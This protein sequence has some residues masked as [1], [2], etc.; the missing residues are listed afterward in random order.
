MEL[1][2]TS[3]DAPAEG[4]LR[5]IYGLSFELSRTYDNPCDPAEIAAEAEFELPS[6][7]RLVVPAFWFQDYAVV[8]GTESYEQYLP[9]GTAH[10]RARFLASEPGA[11]QVRLRARDRG[12]PAAEAG[13]F[14]CAIGTESRARGPVGRHP[15][16]P[17]ALAFADGFPYHPRGHNVAFED[18]N[19]ELDGSSYYRA[20]LSSLAAA[21]ENWTRFW[22]TDFARTALEWGRSHFSGFYS[23]AGVYSQRAAWRVDR[24]MD[25]ALAGDIQV[26]LVLND[27]GQFSSYVN[28]RW[29]EGNPYGS[30][31]GGPVPQ[32][33]PELFFTNPSAREL[34]RRRLRYIVARWGA[35]P[36]LLCWELWNEVQFAGSQARNFRSDA[37]TRSAVVEWHRE[38]ASRLK[39]LDP[40]GHMVT[41]SS[42]DPGYPGW[43]PIWNL[44][45][46]DMVQ[47]HHYAQPAAAR[48]A[49][50]V[51]YVDAA[52]QAYGKPV[53]VAEM[54]VKASAEPESNYNP[55]TFR[56]NT[57][58]PARERTGANRGHLSAGTTLRNG[59]WAAAMRR[60]G[61]MNWWWGCY[62]HPD[63]RQGRGSPDFPLNERLFP[64]LAE[65][66]GGEHLAPPPQ[67]AALAL[68]GELVGYGL[69]GADRAYVW[70][71][72]A[73]E[74]YDSGFGPA[75]AED[76]RVEGASLTLTGLNSGSYVVSPFA[77]EAGALAAPEFL[78]VAANGRLQVP[79]PPVTG[80]IALK[81]T[82]GTER[83]WGVVPRSARVWVTAETAGT[84]VTGHARLHPAHGSPAPAA[85]AILTL[86]Q[87][88][89]PVS[90]LMVPAVPAARSCWSAAEIGAPAEVGWAAANP[91]D[92]GAVARL[93]LFDASGQLLRTR[94]LEL[95]PGGHTARFLFE[96]FPGVSGPFRGTLHV[97]SDRPLAALTL[98]GTQNERGEFVLTTLPA[99]RGSE[100]EA[101]GAVVL[102]QAT[103]GGGYQTEWLMVNPYDVGLEGTL[104]FHRPDGSPWA[105]AVNG[106][107]TPERDY[108][109]APHGIVREI[110]SGAGATVEPGYCTLDAGDG[111]LPVAAAVI[112]FSRPGLQSET[113]VPFVRPAFSAATFWEGGSE[114]DTGVAL[115]NSSSEA[116]RVRLELFAR[117]GIEKKLQTEIDLPPGHHT[118]RLL[119]ELFPELPP[120]HGL[121]RCA[122]DGPVG[123]MALRMRT[124]PRGDLLTSSLRMGDAGGTAELVFPRLAFGGAY[125]ERFVLLNPGDTTAEGRL[126]FFDSS[127][128]PVQ[129]LFK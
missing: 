39:E 57:A 71:R 64:P 113:G 16:D 51:E 2:F 111:R 1:A 9:V 14:A 67:N 93:E 102:P 109:I 120:G 26:Q 45:A 13:P 43:S 11:H 35:Y 59:I 125:E 110:S 104:R 8:S 52:G 6:G 105:P 94:T 122:S 30:A 103:D 63:P 47:S 98:R 73:R 80:D 92:A 53:V 79:L 96:L 66:W 10:W 83:A 70:L 25:L 69:Q 76:R 78:A 24:F 12:G 115:A 22:M 44:P 106:T 86:F 99:S 37:A 46:V 58:V 33:N 119:T 18:G 7:R 91:G 124:T 3:V 55:D 75:S 112:R 27:H 23:G 85:G 19:P 72:D 40:F 107:A 97:T 87:G 82:D 41:T 62:L 129:M 68:T 127:G 84:A 74:A 95:P 101:R 89:N 4:L 31:E 116:R 81:I 128:A 114:T 49:R 65:F 34:F 48:D 15:S 60:S 100:P 42:D 108:S 118:A 38:M 28:P 21:G 29:D 121:L 36:N 117:A 32:G 20:L 5:Q 88:G 77:T 61:A 123:F 54:G 56:A 126:L 90:E 50:I 17:L